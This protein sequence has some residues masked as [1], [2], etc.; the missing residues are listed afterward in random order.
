MI[1]RETPRHDHAPTDGSE[2]ARPLPHALLAAFLAGPSLPAAAC[3]G[4]APLFDLEV[5]GESDEQRSARHEQARAICRTCAARTEC[6]AV[7]TDHLAPIAGVWSG[8]IVRR[9]LWLREESRE[10][11]RRAGRGAGSDRGSEGARRPDSP[12]PSLPPAPPA[13]TRARA[14]SAR[15]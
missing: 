6:A 10:A 11:R 3:A 8:R 15:R 9:R 13:H 4:R 2:R 1:T 14:K 12:A 7:V 5:D